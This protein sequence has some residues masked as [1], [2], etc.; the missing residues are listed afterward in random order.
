MLLNNT[1]Q[2]IKFINKSGISIPNILPKLL[3]PC[4]EPPPEPT[5]FSL[6]NIY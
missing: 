4:L 5:G 1:Q 6:K 2:E 3:P